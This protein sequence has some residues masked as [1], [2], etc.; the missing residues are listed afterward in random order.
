MQ[1]QVV[2]NGV[3]QEGRQ[4]EK[5]GLGADAQRA[6]R[7]PFSPNHRFALV[8]ECKS[9]LAGGLHWLKRA[10]FKVNRKTNAVCGPRRHVCKHALEYYS[11]GN[12]FR[13]DQHQQRALLSTGVQ[14]VRGLRFLH[15][16]HRGPLQNTFKPT[17]IFHLPKCV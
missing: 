14:C 11:M 10:I 1:R 13:A 7:L 2:P 15:R 4:R 9:I 12:P 6:R 16:K 3:L 5:A 8:C 17:L